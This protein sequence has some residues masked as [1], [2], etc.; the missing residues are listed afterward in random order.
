M[1]VPNTGTAAPP[2]NRKKEVVCENFVPFTNF[3]S[4]INNTQID[5]ANDIDI[6]MSMY[7]LVEYSEKYSKTSGRLRQ[8]SRN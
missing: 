1:T 6:V 3:I 5:T 4:E 2:N 8:Y 7:N